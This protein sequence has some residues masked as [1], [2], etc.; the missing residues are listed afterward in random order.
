MDHVIGIEPYERVGNSVSAQ[1]VNLA[2]DM[3][4]AKSASIAGRG[5][6]SRQT[7]K[8]HIQKLNVPEQK[9]DG[10]K[11]VVTELH[12]YADEDHVHMQKPGK[13]KGKKDQIVPL[14]TVTEGTKRK[15][16]SRNEVKDKIHFVDEGFNPS[17]LWK[18]VEGYIAKA[19]EID[20]IDKIYLHG[21]GGSWIKK[22]LESF[23]QTEHVMDGYHYGKALRKVTRMFPKQQVRLNI[24]RAIRENEPQ[25]AIEYL[26]KLLGKLSCIRVYRENGNEIKAEDFKNKEIK[27]TYIKYA[28]ELIA[29]NISGAIDWSIFDGESY[30]YDKSSGTQI[31]I[32]T[33]G[34]NYGIL[35]N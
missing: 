34:T 30:I 27:D 23:V 35:R 14:V 2:S 22:G 31:L 26:S 25:T 13:A 29:E 5:E 16:K 10:E 24:E 4:Y 17:D 9:L 15:Y 7:V 21:D 12:I 11:R 8:N 33:L 3:S 18:R 20:E 6:L 28:D 19:Y 1:M 32:E